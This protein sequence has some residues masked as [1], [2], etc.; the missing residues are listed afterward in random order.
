MC[1]ASV[2]VLCLAMALSACG[3][4]RGDSADRD[5]VADARTGNT[6][7][8]IAGRT[9]SCHTGGSATPLTFAADGTLRG[10]LLDSDVTG[11][12]HVT[13][14]REIHTHVRAGAVSVRDDLRQSGSRWTGKT[15]SC[16]G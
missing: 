12:W 15:I 16:S 5:A 4:S 3:G 1:R 2:T 8:P 11:T 14:R 9:L 7:A 6:N 10:R 13:P